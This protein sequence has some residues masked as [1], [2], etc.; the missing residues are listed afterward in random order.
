MIGGWWAEED[1]TSKD[2]EEVISTGF[3]KELWKPDLQAGIL[4]GKN[5][6]IQNVIS[7]RECT[8]HFVNI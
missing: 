8:N 6:A 1:I 3:L 2:K 5:V 4:N 7:N